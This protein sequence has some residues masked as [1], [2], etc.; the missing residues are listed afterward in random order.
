MNH[1]SGINGLKDLLVGI[2]Y[3]SIGS[4]AF[5]LSHAY[6]IGSLTHMGPG[7]FPAMVGVILSILGAISI[8]NGWRRKT[9]DPI[10]KHHIAPLFLILA[11][12]LSFSLLIERAGLIVA[13]AALILFACYRRLISNPIEVLATLLVLAG[14][15]VFIF[16]YCFGMP[17]PVFWWQ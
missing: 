7:Y 12:T 13:I 5:I 8:I 15:S 14:F 10:E 11:G 9:P 4:A 17:I 1:N 16:V 3:I 6:T 2:I